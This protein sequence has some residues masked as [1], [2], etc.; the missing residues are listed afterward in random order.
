MTRPARSGLGSVAVGAG[1]GGR[2]L[3]AHTEIV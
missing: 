1:F 2:M 3:L